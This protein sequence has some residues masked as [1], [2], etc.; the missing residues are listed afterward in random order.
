MLIVDLIL[1]YFKIQ[2]LE[3]LKII[4]SPAL[5]TSCKFYCLN[6]NSIMYIDDYLMIMTLF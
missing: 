6:F 5:A 4:L 1:S 3:V 2:K